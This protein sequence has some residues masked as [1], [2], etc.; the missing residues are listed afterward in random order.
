MIVHSKHNNIFNNVKFIIVYIVVFWANDHFG[1][2]QHDEM[3][4][5]KKKLGDKPDQMP[6]G[7]HKSNI[8]FAGIESRPP[9]WETGRENPVHSPQYKVLSFQVLFELY[10]LWTLRR[11]PSFGRILWVCWFSPMNAIMSNPW[12]II[13]LEL[14]DKYI[15]I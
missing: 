7:R 13:R 5:V 3:A 12:Y 4:A 8:E 2:I 15:I 6:H 10:L 14:S 1:F 9:H 11:V